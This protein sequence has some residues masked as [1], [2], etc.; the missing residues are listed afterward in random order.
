MS[1]KHL[2]CEDR[3]KIWVVSVYRKYN[4]IPMR[5]REEIPFPTP[6]LDHLLVFPIELPSAWQMR[7]HVSPPFLT[8]APSCIFTMQ[9]WQWPQLCP[10][11]LSVLTSLEQPVWDLPP[12]LSILFPTTLSSHLVQQAGHRTE[13]MPL[14]YRVSVPL[15]LNSYYF[16]VQLGCLEKAVS[17]L[18]LGT[19]WTWCTIHS[20]WRKR[21]TSLKVI[22]LGNSRS[23]N[24]Y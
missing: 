22:K 9:Q 24:Y 21:S 19:Q 3:L 8:P 16:S 7:L 4:W 20:R 14:F 15:L 23:V 5:L 1:L 10:P 6:V 11:P 17:S 2:S 13:N 12:C 18:N